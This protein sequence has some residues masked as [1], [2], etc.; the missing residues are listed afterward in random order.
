[1]NLIQTHAIIETFKSHL[2]QMN[3]QINTNLWKIPDPVSYQSLILSFCN[4]FIRPYRKT[5]SKP[6]RFI[7]YISKQHSS[8]IS[9]FLYFLQLR[10]TSIIFNPKLILKL[11]DLDLFFFVFEPGCIEEH[12]NKLLKEGKG[13]THKGKEMSVIWWK[14]L[15]VCNL[16]FDGKIT[17][18]NSYI[19]S[20]KR[21]FIVSLLIKWFLVQRLCYNVYL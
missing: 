10:Y 8:K 16:H 19:S 18:R 9:L 21:T 12:I 7:I 20:S 15:R 13:T 14:S 6:V 11:R 1:M 3:E 4:M 5:I 17:I 2:K